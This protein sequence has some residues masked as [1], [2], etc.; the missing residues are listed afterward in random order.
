MYLGGLLCAA[1]DRP[2]R[3]IVVNFDQTSAGIDV[4]LPRILEGEPQ[5]IILCEFIKQCFEGGLRNAGLRA[6]DDPQGTAAA[7]RRARFMRAHRA[8]RHIRL[9]A[10]SCDGAD[11]ARAIAWLEGSETGIVV[12]HLGLVPAVFY[13][14]AFARAG[15]PSVFEGQ[16]TA[17][18]AISSGR[19]YI[20][21]P[22]AAMILQHRY[23][24]AP[25]LP[26]HEA[27][28][29]YLDG[30]SETLVEGA[31]GTIAFDEAASRIGAFITGTRAG[32]NDS[33]AAYFGSLGRDMAEPANDKLTRGLLALQRTIRANTVAADD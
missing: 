19:P 12:A 11:V 13:T 9:L 7:E 6:A 2:L 33:I 20:H 21:V 3:A 30:V 29:T 16:A 10:P 24:A 1:E 5:P 4:A 32:P 31:M 23:P 14:A 17:S 15:L 26:N 8:A 18:I 27:I 28:R 25:R 22:N